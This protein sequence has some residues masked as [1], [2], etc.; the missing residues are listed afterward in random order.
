MIISGCEHGWSFWFAPLLAQRNNLVRLKQLK[1]IIVNKRYFSKLYEIMKCSDLQ[2]TTWLGF[3]GFAFST[4]NSDMKDMRDHLKINT[5]MTEWI[6]QVL[7]FLCQ[8]LSIN[9]C[10]SSYFQFPVHKSKLPISGV[11]AAFSVTS[12]RT[13]A[14]LEFWQ[15]GI[16]L[17]FSFLE[18]RK[19]TNNP[20]MDFLDVC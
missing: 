15:K 4:T 12:G 5:G 11:T 8:T 18:R 19:H 20:K 2:A 1:C 6:I 3:L 9:S 10:I 14:G 7:F 13:T 16:I 17:H